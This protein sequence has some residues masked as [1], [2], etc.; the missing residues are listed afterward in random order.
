MKINYYSNE[1]NKVYSD[2]N[3]SSKGLSKEEAKQ[4]L[5]EHGLNQINNDK[6]SNVILLF[7]SQFKDIMLFILFIAAA[8]SFFL[9]EYSDVIVILSVLLLNAVLGFIQEFKAEKALEALKKLNIPKVKVLRDSLIYEIKSN[10]V[11]VGDILFLEDGDIICAD[12]RIIEYSNFKVD[13]SSLTG[14]SLPIEKDNLPI[15]NVVPLSEQKNMVFSGSLIVS[16]SAKVIVTST[17]MNTELGKIANKLK[18]SKI[19]P[20]P[21]Q[22]RLANLSKWLSLIVV[23]IALLI[24]GI[25][26]YQ[27]RDVF[28]MIL[29]SVSIAVA[30]IPEGLP[31]V[32][33]IVL[34]I[35]VIKLSKKNTIIR[36]LS[37][38]E[39]LG[40]TQVICSDKT[41]TLTKNKMT[42]KKIYLDK[43]YND[44][45]YINY[46]NNIHFYNCL[47]LCNSVK[48]IDNEIKGDPTEI[49]LVEYYKNTANK[50]LS[51]NK[52]LDIPFDSVRKMM[53]VV[54]EI[55]N[56][57]ICYS[58]GALDYLLTKCSY[59]YDNKT[60]RLLSLK[61]KK[62][63]LKEME[64]LGKDALRV[65]GLAY[66][67]VNNLS[68]IENDLIFIGMV[69]MID[70][71]KE[72][73][74]EAINK[75]KN[76]GISTIMITGDHLSTASSIAKELNILS[77][78]NQIL[79]GLE[80]DNLSKEELEHN[81]FNYRV[82][83]RVTPEHKVR[84]VEAFQKR[85]KIVA[86]SGDGVN[87]APSLKKANIGVSMGLNGTE[88]AKNAS[89]MILS[90][91]NF[92]T[93]VLAVEEGRKI[94]ENITKAISY[95]LSCNLGEIITL[96][97]ATLLNFKILLPIHI[98]WMNLVTDSLPALAL[99]LDENNDNVMNESPR[100]AN[101]GFFSGK[102][103][104]NILYQGVLQGMLTLLSFFIGI[105]FF[106]LNTAETMA[107]TTIVFIQLFHSLNM[108][109]SKNSIFS[110][111]QNIYLLLTIILGVICQ[112]CIIY[113]PFLAQVFKVS[114]LNLYQWGVAILLATLIIPFI[115]LTKI[116][117]RKIR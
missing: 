70:P 16:G 35:S 44:N 67:N 91:D 66:K 75:C 20:T 65:I 9:K 41:G 19:E 83:C 105:Y 74:K 76:A 8:I 62:I 96:F 14:E 115:E 45:D 23:I 58:K 98:L 87:D 27:G 106:D 53:S 40:C 48:I 25:G 24:F 28:E 88:V 36:K 30:A 94:Y 22:K 26:I 86:M 49:A 60:I 61:E 79:S 51:Y 32:V 109:S 50:E 69:G 97:I 2:L 54:Y 92:T 55:N 38:V 68:N 89:D 111:K 5:N 47:K 13:E 33:T 63:I 17:G 46:N 52:V 1:I 29:V 59:I 80:L 112:V 31:A 85:G 56:K 21:L 100:N 102:R 95:L 11:V 116:Y 107:F 78:D 110:K 117:K 99:G 3:S 84:I 18:E 108:R 6:K 93:I 82:F 114:P 7:L 4:R 57:K 101:A 12:A 73:V 10:E 81:I 37:S 15:S 113:I 103:G 42:V 72:G 43:L 64:R 71:P 77:D 39:T 90:D 34:A 104:I